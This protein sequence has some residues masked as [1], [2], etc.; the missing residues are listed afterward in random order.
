MVFL[1]KDHKMLFQNMQRLKPLFA[2]IAFELA[3]TLSGICVLKKIKVTAFT[4]SK[5]LY[6][7]YVTSMSSFVRHS[8]EEDFQDLQ[9]P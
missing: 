1:V 4:L 7:V 2:D 5:H 8:K 9:L 3:V 6:Q